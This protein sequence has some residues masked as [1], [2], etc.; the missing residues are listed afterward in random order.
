MGTMVENFRAKQPPHPAN[1]SECD[2]QP[3]KGNLG[4]KEILDARPIRR[5]NAYGEPVRNDEKEG[6]V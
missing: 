2:E 4:S 6:A 1:K 5:T 3:S